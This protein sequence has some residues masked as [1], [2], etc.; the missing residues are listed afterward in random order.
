[1]TEYE[2]IVPDWDDRLP[3]SAEVDMLRAHEILKGSIETD[4]VV[5]A[6]TASQNRTPTKGDLLALWRKRAGGSVTPVLVHVTYVDAG[7]KRVALFGP[8][9]EAEPT[10]GVEPDLASRLVAEAL[11]STSPSGL[12]AQLRERLQGLRSDNPSCLRNEGLFAS[13]VLRTQAQETGWSSLTDAGRALTGRRGRDL[14]ADLGYDI[15]PV[16]EGNVLRSRDASDRRAAVVLLAADESLDNP[17]AR[18][19][20]TSAVTHGLSVARRENLDWLVVLGGSRIRLYAT[21]ERGVGHKGQTQ[22]FVE[23]DLAFLTE[24]EAGFLPLIF[25]PGA[26]AH[27]GSVDRLLNDSSRFATGL[28][29]RL[30]DRVYE[31][32]IPSLAI[33]VATR[34][35]V[36]A[37]SGDERR[38][39]LDEAYHQAMIILFRLL[40][41]A[42]A[43]DRQLLPFDLNE[44]YTRNALKTLA[45][46][47]LAVDEPDD[48][49]SQ[50]LW[51]DL[52]QVWRVID[53]GDMSGWGVPA[54][55]GGLFTRDASKN[56]SGAE[57]YNLN[58]TNDQIAPALR[59]LLIDETSDGTVG[60]VDFRSLS[61]REF[62]TI[63]EGLLESGLDIAEAHLTLEDNNY[64]LA[65]PEDVIAV[66][67]GEVYFHS[68]SGSRKAT[69]SYF[70]KPFAVNHLLEHSLEP[71]LAEHLA[72]VKSR[73]DAGATKSAAEHLWEFRAADLSMGSGHFLV[74][75]VDRIEAAF[76]SFLAENPL[77]EVSVELDRLRTSAAQQLGLEAADSGIDNGAL[78]R[79]QIARR[80]IYGVDLNEVAVELARLALWIH[81]F[82]PGLPLSFLNHGLVNGNSLSGIGTV[83]EIRRALD[84]ANSRELKSKALTMTA[85]ESAL[86]EFAERVESQ[87]RALSDLPDASIGDVANAGRIHAEI[88][89]ALEPLTALCDLITAER[90]TRHLGDVWESQIVYD[91]YGK[92]PRP[93]RQRA[94]HPDRILLTA[95]AAMLTASTAEALEAAVLAHPHLDRARRY[96]EELNVVHFPVA[97]PELFRTETGFHCILGNP[98]WDKVRHEPQQF[99]VTVR[100]GLNLLEDTERD[101][102]IERLR[103]TRPTDAAREQAEEADRRQQQELFKVAFTLRGGTHVELAQLVLERALRTLRPTG[104]LGL[105]LPRQFTVLAGWKDLREVITQYFD[106]SVVQGRNHGEW[107][108]D[109]IHNSYAVVLLCARPSTVGQ[110]RIAVARSVPDILGINSA[111][112]TLTPEEIAELSETHVLPWFATKADRDVFDT[113]RR[114]PSLQAGGGWVSGRHD[115]RWD[116]RGTGPDKS[117]AVR[118]NPDGDA[119]K[120]LMTAHVGAF[121]LKDK[122]YKQFVNDLDG[123]VAKDRGIVEDDEANVVVSSAHPA[124]IVRH[125]SRSDDARTLIATLLPRQGVLHN[126]GYVH[127]IALPDD[128][129]PPT[130]LALLGYTNTYVADWWA[131]RFVDRH[132]T[133]PVIN[134]LALPDW[135]P[136][137]IDRAAALASSL[138]A[139][140]NY[141]EGPGD[142]VLTDNETASTDELIVELNVLALAGFGLSATDFALIAEDFSNKGMPPSIKNAIMLAIDAAE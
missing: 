132:I 5:V 127:A 142:I 131:R 73:M 86:G 91:R 130:T 36:R 52:T 98:P 38:E 7:P 64:V 20:N 125:P 103:R 120:V 114:H 51:D 139:R 46:D 126:K 35:N 116:F 59:G 25:A 80:C 83:D 118:T 121:S 22:T 110:V 30:R 3:W 71:A 16:P 24:E 107:I 31:R 12:T 85:M 81:T 78:L 34:L 76:S 89:A 10:T 57:T 53:T 141:T 75:A 2:E 70:T 11:E 8:D 42:Y 43:E 9:A 21:E 67:R 129:T 54:Y 49:K 69:G 40:F 23:L 137:R 135:T 87:V 133:A 32:V 113:M 14:I 15:E 41:V 124:I 65:Q 93:K 4:L 79:R 60:P 72:S 68:R 92:N 28:S 27:G 140:N 29:E 95:N 109:G 17:L 56:S 44:R 33:A 97:F 99:W 102:E 13:W 134:Q 115:A 108:F 88:R 106:V 119:W 136:P 90:A 111:W 122:P 39:A 66:R 50:T 18:F 128:T 104:R 37:S 1:M 77:P 94:P 123:L 26:L 105:V 96:A 47:L 61:V 63:Y 112:L 117:L 84:E 6:A 101:A 55:N 19:H 74:A 82:V 58:L 138:L 62:G 45:A 48:P 100:P